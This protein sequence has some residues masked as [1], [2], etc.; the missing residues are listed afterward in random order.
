MDSGLKNKALTHFYAYVDY[1]N[2]D[3]YYYP[4]G[5]TDAYSEFSLVQD[6]DF[7][8]VSPVAMMKIRNYIRVN[9]SLTVLLNFYGRTIL[10]NNYPQYIE[11]FLVAKDYELNFDHHLPF[12][13]LPSV[14]SAERNLFVGLLGLRVRVAPNQYIKAEGNILF[15]DRDLLSLESYRSLWG[16]ALT[17][18]Y[19]SPVGPIEF[20]LGYSNGYEKLVF[21]ANAGFWF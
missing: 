11:N 2:L 4:A 13:G 14:W 21:T 9:P 16:T 1:D 3:N 12:Y 18:A 6:F 5:G 17:Y 7:N 8:D 10:S 15:Q 19:N 20:S